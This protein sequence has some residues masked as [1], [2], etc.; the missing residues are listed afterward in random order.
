MLTHSLFRL[1]SISPLLSVMSIWLAATANAADAANE[2]PNIVFILADDLGWRDLGCYGSTFHATPNL[3]RLAA[4]GMRFTQAYAASPLCSP[5]RSS[6]LTGQYPARIG[7]TSPSCHL[8]AVQLEK[9]LSAGGQNVKVLN[10]ESLTRLKSEY[11]TLAE[12]LRDAGYST[13]HFGKWHL[14]HNLPSR[15]GDAFEPRDQ[16]FSSDFPHSPTAAGP[17]GGYLA[18]WRFIKD[19]AIKS[20]PGEHIE[21]RMSTEAARF[22]REHRDRPFFLNYWAFSVH[23]P[24]NARRDDIEKFQ[25][26]VDEKNPQHNALYAAMVHRLDD[27]IS[28]LMQAVDDAGVADRTI[29][30]FFSDNGGYAYPPKATDPAGFDEIPATSNLPLRSGKASLYEGGTREPCLVVWP[31]KIRA[32]ATNDSLFHSTDFF[33]TLTKLCGVAAPEGVRFDGVDQSSVLLGGAAVRDRVFCHF[34]HGSANQAKQISGFLPGTYVRRGDWKLIRFHADADDGSDRFELYD[35]KS[36]VGESNNLAAQ[37]PEIVRELNQLLDEFL[38]DTEAVVPRRN[39]MYRAAASETSPSA[40]P[41][42]SPA[43]TS[44]KGNAKTPAAQGDEADP[45]LEGWRARNCSASVKNGVVTIIGKNSTPFLGV[46][47][48]LAGP[49]KLQLRARVPQGGETKVEWFAPTP[50]G[51]TLGEPQSKPLVWKSTTD[52][53]DLMLEIPAEGQ[54]GIFRVYVPAQEKPVEIDWIEL[55]S[56]ARTRRWEFNQTPK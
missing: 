43:K 42:K 13:A 4:R 22:I 20:E 49:L 40:D 19:P 51:A 46:G 45:L 41:G 39:P 34:P 53:Q 1:S 30:V 52:W 38:R 28:R 35:L 21:T 25:D 3:D 37:R 54:V 17:G 24:W 18:P 55:K 2:K 12:V 9:K 32:G 47:A 29:F 50:A 6:I 44:G 15:P 31:G 16:G 10:A 23:S 27:A 56:A 8:P 5:T 33:P 11:V 26:R 36:D 7:I 14:G 48:A